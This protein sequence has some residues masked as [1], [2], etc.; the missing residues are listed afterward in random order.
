MRDLRELSG[1]DAADA[2]M[3]ALAAV[4][5]L[6]A[7]APPVPPAAR[8]IVAAP[9]L[10]A[11][12]GYV[13]VRIAFPRPLSPGDAALLAAG[14]SIA[15]LA[16]AGLVLDQ[17]G[18][19]LTPGAW[20]VAV[21]LWAAAGLLLARRRRVPGPGPGRIRLVRPRPGQAAAFLLAAAIAATALALDIRGAEAQERRERF[22][23]LW[24]VPSGPGRV[25]VGIRSGEPGTTTYRLT[26]SDGPA[27]LRT[28][29]GVDLAWGQQWQT[30]VVLPAG[31]GPGDE[32]A[33]LA[34]RG[35]SQ[36][37]VRAVHVAA[38]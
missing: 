5:T 6:A 30:M 33:A 21:D 36:A 17:V 38:P 13:L 24:L 27:P 29:A 22:V 35:S 9:L 20:L 18:P 4:A 32:L 28:W 11:L 12:P 7:V 26:L 23:E 25:V 34:Y 16:L 19:G 2:A 10:L 1:W 37:P 15:L 3:A 14:L 8:A 31:V